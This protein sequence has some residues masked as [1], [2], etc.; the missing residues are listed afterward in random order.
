VRHSHF[1][2]S[3]PLLL[4]EGL[5]VRAELSDTSALTPSP[6]PGVRGEGRN[7]PSPRPLS[8]KERGEY[9]TIEF[10]CD[11]IQAAQNRHDVTK[12]MSLDQV[13]ESREVDVRWCSSPGAVRRAAAVGHDIKPKLAVGR[14][15]AAVH[16][17]H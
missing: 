7:T 9:L 5:G 3:S 4:G 14:L 2:Y 17:L 10:R 6:S 8:Q 11:D 13:R 16:L 12:L 15:G 1:L